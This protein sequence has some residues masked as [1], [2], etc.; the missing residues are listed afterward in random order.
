MTPIRVPQT[1]KMPP[2]THTVVT[3]PTHPL[4]P[5]SY[6]GS[7]RI[8]DDTVHNDGPI[9]ARSSEATPSPSTTL[10]SSAKEL[11]FTIASIAN[12]DVDWRT[13]GCFVVVHRQH[14]LI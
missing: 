8:D 2:H 5:P 1:Q 4:T 13:R 10:D 9:H 11:T 14:S 3:P 12:G 6:G 7:R